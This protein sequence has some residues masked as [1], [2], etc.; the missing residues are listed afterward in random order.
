MMIHKLWSTLTIPVLALVDAD[1][2]GVEILC[3]Y[4]FGSKVL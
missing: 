4:K 3:I 1:P 2:Y